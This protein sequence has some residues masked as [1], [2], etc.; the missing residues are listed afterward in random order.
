M[1]KFIKIASAE[2]NRTYFHAPVIPASTALRPP[3]TGVVLGVGATEPRMNRA[4]AYITCMHCQALGHYQ[5]ACPVGGGGGGRGGGHYQDGGGRGGGGR[6]R[7][8]GG[9]HGRGGGR[10][11][12]VVFPL[13]IAQE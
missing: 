6:G 4:G 11:E 9:R 1:A 7:G 5:D 13:A 3:P 8:R 2:A 10:G 12:P